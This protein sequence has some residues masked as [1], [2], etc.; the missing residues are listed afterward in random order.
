L[1]VESIVL[2]LLGAAFGI[3]LGYFGLGAMKSAL[4]DGF[5]GLRMAPLNLR[6]LGLTTLV[7]FIASI[8]FGLFPALQARRVDIRSAQTGRGV[9]GGS[10]SL[11]RRALTTVQ[12]GVAVLLL[13]GAGLLIRTFQGLS[14]LTPGFDSANVVTAS[15]SL[16]DARYRT[17]EQT[18][19][20][21]D[22]TLARMHEING[23]ENAAV[24]LTLPYERGLNV[25]FWKPGD[26]NIRL[27][28]VV[29]VSPDF[30][31]ALRI[32]LLRGREIEP[33]DRPQTPPIV[34]ANAAFVR[35]N[36]PNSDPLAAQIGVGSPTELSQIVGI[37]GDVQQR[38]GWGS[39]GP[40]GPVPTIYLPA[41]Q[42]AVGV[43][44]FSPKWIIRTRGPVQNVEQLMQAAVASVDPLLPLSG[45]RTLD[46][47]KSKAFAFQRSMALLLSIAAGLALFLAVCGIYAMMANAVAERSREFGIRMALGSTPAE[48]IRSGA[49]PGIISAALGTLA[50]LAVSLWAVR[51]LQSIVWGVRPVDP[52]TFVAVAVIVVTVAILASIIPALRI[53]RVNPA[54]T[55]RQE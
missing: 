34:V 14:A 55:L 7:S 31:A 37:V 40:M 22:R 25:P 21:F 1:I 47:I 44:Y 52:T 49:R 33:S 26:K 43:G 50:G 8:L 16:R 42:G 30:F 9:L 10:R 20:L 24:A 13:I 48:A 5:E 35:A 38:A 11:L 15:F 12:V 46:E 36:F 32:P 51:A 29:F 53:A 39:F 27:T 2:G 6:V 18:T 19:A 17:A 23:V 3:A 54:D 28:N 45:F 41:A 4:A